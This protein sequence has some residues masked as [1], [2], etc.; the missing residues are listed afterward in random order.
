MDSSRNLIIIIIIISIT[1]SS[2]IRAG[3]SNNTSK[4]VTRVINSNSIARNNKIAVGCP[5]QNGKS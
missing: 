4:I 2:N 5:P 3:T 1:S